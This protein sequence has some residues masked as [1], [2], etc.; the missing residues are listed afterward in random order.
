MK[1]VLKPLDINGLR[2]YRVR[3]SFEGHPEHGYAII[4]A[5]TSPSSARKI[6]ERMDKGISWGDTP[7]TY[8]GLPLN[9][10]QPDS[11]QEDLP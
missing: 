11:W 8:T 1:R 6:V 5:S 3:V 9:V 4:V 7:P 2:L 10:L